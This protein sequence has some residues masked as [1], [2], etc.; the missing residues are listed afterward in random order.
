MVE[1]RPAYYYF[2]FDTFLK[3]TRIRQLAIANFF[4][5]PT[6]CIEFSSDEGYNIISYILIT[7][8]LDKFCAIIR[9]YEI[10]STT[11]PE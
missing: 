8:R 4:K 5:I 2:I 3:Y 7:K 6:V 10:K 9:E 11:N 1:N